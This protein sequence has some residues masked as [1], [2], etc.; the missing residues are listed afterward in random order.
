M[1]ISQ[2]IS[3]SLTGT[4]I[5]HELY[6]NTRVFLNERKAENDIEVLSWWKRCFI[7]SYNYS[8]WFKVKKKNQ[9]NITTNSKN[10]A[11]L[12]TY[13]YVNKLDAKGKADIILLLCVKRL[14]I[15]SIRD[16]RKI[17]LNS[18]NYEIY[19]PKPKPI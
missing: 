6:Q 11:F 7:I 19:S 18:L 16:K 5:K 12:V 2:T 10:L 3:L 14:E 13:Y 8:D 15:Q 1:L 4:G 17:Y 9:V